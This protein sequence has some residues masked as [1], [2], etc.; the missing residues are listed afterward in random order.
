M[1]RFFLW[2]VFL[3]AG[4]GGTVELPPAEPVTLEV[5]KAMPPESKFEAATLERLKA[6]EPRL[7]KE[8]EWARFTRTVLIPARKKEFPK[9]LPRT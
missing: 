6:G 8:A 1:K 7:Q 5:W 3:A 2:M 4:C 9:G